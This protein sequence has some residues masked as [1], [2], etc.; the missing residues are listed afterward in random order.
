MHYYRIVTSPGRAADL[1][2]TGSWLVGGRWNPVGVHAL[3]LSENPALSMLELLVHADTRDLPD[4]LWLVK[5]EVDAAAP[6]R[7]VAEEDLPADWRMPDHL[8]LKRM[9]KEWLSDPA[10]IGFHAPSAV[11]PVQ[12]N[13]ILHPGHPA[14]QRFVRIIDQ[15]EIRPDARLL[16]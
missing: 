8:G 6:I 16:A 2:G 10:F 3:Y 13:L 7:S 14:F 1:S 9:G 4:L 15:Q 11:L 5:L 12:R